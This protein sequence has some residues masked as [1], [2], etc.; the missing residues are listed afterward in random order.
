MD[1]WI[2]FM[3]IVFIVLVVFLIISIIDIQKKQQKNIEKTTNDLSKAYLNLKLKTL[4]PKELPV[5][6]TEIEDDIYFSDK[7]I[8][9]TYENFNKIKGKVIKLNYS[10]A[11]AN[12]KDNKDVFLRYKLHDLFFSSSN[13]LPLNQMDLLVSQKN[14]YF[15]HPL[16]A[17]TVPIKEIT[18]ITF[19]WERNRLIKSKQKILGVEF[20]YNNK[21]YF[22]LFNDYDAAISFVAHIIS[23]S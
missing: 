11:I 22:L 13:F 18:N 19:F 5:K 14:I 20:S 2:I 17:Q 7:V 10:Y 16:D 3:I 4:N 12:L 1:Q 15:F 21:P 6:I 8:W 23:L 9:G